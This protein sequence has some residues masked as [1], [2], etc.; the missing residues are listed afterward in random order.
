MGGLVASAWGITAPFWF[1]FVGSAIILAVIWRSLLQ[2]AHADEQARANA[3]AAA[4]DNCV[5]A[6]V[7]QAAWKPGPARPGPVIMGR[8][9]LPPAG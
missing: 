8:F 1:A 2:I 9:A 6:H 5:Y 3:N 7:A 4:P